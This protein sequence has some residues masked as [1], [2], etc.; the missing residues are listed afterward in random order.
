MDFQWSFFVD[1]GIIAIALLLATLIR[2]RVRFFQR[3]LIPNALTAG[4]ILLPFYNFVAPHIGLTNAGLG[5]I[6][7]HLLS[8]SFVAMTLRRPLQPRGKSSRGVMG[9]TVALLF[10]YGMQGFVGLLLTALLIN[11]V[12]PD[13]F[14]AFG[15]LVPLGFALGPGQA[16]A[17]GGG[18]EPFGFVGAGTVGLTFAALG[19][20]LACFIGVF[21]INYGY[22]KGWAS[23]TA[24][25][26]AA[27]VGPKERQGRGSGI[28]DFDRENPIGA[29]LT[30]Y[31][32]SI[33]TM[34][35]NLGIV[36]AT[37]F[38]SYLFLRFLTWALGF[39]GEL[40]T[41]LATNLWGISFVFAMLVALVV[42]RVLHLTKWYPILD[43]GS[44][45]RISGTSVDIMVAAAVG[46][47][48]LVVVL[49]YWFPIVIVGGIAGL[50]VTL[51]VPWMASRMFTSYR[52]Q[53]TVTIFAAMTGTLPTGLAMLRVLDPEFSTPVAGDYVASSAVVFFAL[54]P[55]ILAMNLPAYSVSRGQP[56]LFWLTV[57]IIGMYML[58][59]IVAFRLMAKKRAFR[60]P[61]R[62][63]YTR[64]A[65]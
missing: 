28:V 15:L 8:I 4:F 10:Q 34:S 50:L 5:E 30:T 62:L 60:Q 3:F 41:D 51:T 42:K 23:P 7:Y 19:F 59:G 43:H 14:P 65:E 22:R 35:V 47:I 33:D 58:I 39:V 20:L 24:A 31:S 1:V 6:V 29:R 16:F 17:I 63:W 25:A 36:L 46:A 27:R 40:G 56:G 18:W 64:D 53:R 38:L 54:I 37:Y 61:A 11:T 55:L 45:A 52:F 2:W 49:D 21:L 26:N 13:L 12:M 44:L 32:D 48:S 57:A 9:N